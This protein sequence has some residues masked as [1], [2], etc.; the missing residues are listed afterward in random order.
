[1]EKVRLMKFSPM[2]TFLIEHALC[3]FYWAQTLVISMLKNKIEA[4]NLILVSRHVWL[5][6]K[7]I[8]E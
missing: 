5:E 6:I 7:V 1:M 3:I 2:Q 8:V 4:N